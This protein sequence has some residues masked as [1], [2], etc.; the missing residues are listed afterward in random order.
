MMLYDDI[1]NVINTSTIYG[2]F[3]TQLDDVAMNGAEGSVV[4]V[5]VTFSFDYTEET[6]A[7][8]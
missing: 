4:Q 3:P 6:V 8:E 7:P 5:S 2:C 1:P